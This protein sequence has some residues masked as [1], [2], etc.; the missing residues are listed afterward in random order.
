[1]MSWQIQAGT[2]RRWAIAFAA[3]LMAVSGDL[4][5][6]QQPSG[7]AAP[8]CTAK[9][10]DST[11]T[12]GQLKI[13][14]YSAESADC[15]QVASE[16]KVLYRGSIEGG[17]TLKLGQTGSDSDIPEIANG[18]DVTGRGHPDLIVSVFTG[19]A[20]CCTSHYLYELE[21]KVRL[22]ARLNDADDD[23]AHF[24]RDPKDRKYYYYTADW[25]FRYW[26]TCFACSPSEVVIL[27]FVD[28]A[29]GGAYHVAFDKMQKPAPKQ[30]AWNKELSTAQ[31]A[32]NDGAVNDMGQA[33]WGVVLDLLYTGH[34]DLA[35]KFVG[36]LGS[37]AQQKP[38]ASLADFCS[39][40]KKSPYWP[41]LGPTLQGPP[42]PCAYTPPA[43]TK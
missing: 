21:P 22:L 16:T 42:L 33:M 12:V 31:K 14:A 40:L 32:V 3:A 1:M 11:V 30:A 4:F 36:A 19:G 13:S 5:A 37:K 28:D 9:N 26:P 23:M 15:L 7:D 2:R 29:N 20:H 34:S 17:G 27:R 41:D 6:Q 35:W 43:G 18:A 10:L 39:L 38:F 8:V 25:T 24:A